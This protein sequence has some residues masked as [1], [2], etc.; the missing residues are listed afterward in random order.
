MEEGLRELETL[1]VME[2][3]HAQ[4]GEVVAGQVPEAS[5]RQKELLDAL[6][7]SLPST[8]PEATVSVGTRKK[9]NG[10]RKPIEK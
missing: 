2:L 6:K 9:I 3:V 10:V 5:Q 7:L 8:V 1:C 4:S